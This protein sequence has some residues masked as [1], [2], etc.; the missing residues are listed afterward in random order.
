MKVS[1]NRLVLLAVLVTVALLSAA[2]A[3][4]TPSDFLEPRQADI[5][6][7]GQV[8]VAE[9]KT[10]EQLMELLEPGNQVLSEIVLAYGQSFS[11]GDTGLVDLSGVF[12]PYS[13][14]NASTGGGR[15]GGGCTVFIRGDANG[16]QDVNIADPNYISAY[17]FASGPPPPRM[18]AADSDDNGSITI[19]DSIYILQWLYQQG[20]KPP[21]PFGRSNG[22]QYFAGLDPTPDSLDAE[23]DL[24]PENF[25]E[26]HPSSGEGDH[27]GDSD[28]DSMWLVPEYGIIKV[29]EIG[30]Y[31]STVF[32]SGLLEDGYV[33]FSLAVSKS[34]PICVLATREGDG[35][36]RVIVLLDLDGDGDAQDSGERRYFTVPDNLL[37]GV[38][39]DASDSG[40]LSRQ[41]LVTLHETAAGE[42]L[43]VISTDSDSDGWL[44]GGAQVAVTDSILEEPKGLSTDGLTG[45][46]LVSGKREINSVLTPAVVF[47]HDTTG[48]K[49]I[50]AGSG[51]PYYDGTSL[52]GDDR[53]PGLHFLEEERTLVVLTI[54]QTEDEGSV[55][56]VKDKEDEIYV[57]QES[58]RSSSL[59]V[60]GEGLV[61]GESV[62]FPRW[63][64]GTC[65]SYGGTDYRSIFVLYGDGWSV[66]VFDV[67]GGIGP[68]S[69]F[70]P[71]PSPVPWVSLPDAGTL[72]SDKSNSHWCYVTTTDASEWGICE[73]P[74]ECNFH[75]AWLVAR[76]SQDF[77]LRAL[78]AYY[79]G[80]ASGKDAASKGRADEYA[81]PPGLTLGGDAQYVWHDGD[82]STHAYIWAESTVTWDIDIVAS[83]W[84]G[85]ILST[86]Y[87]LAGKIDI[88]VTG[89]S[90]GDFASEFF[91]TNEAD[92]N[93][94]EPFD[95]FEWYEV[96][97]REWVDYV[98]Q[99]QC[100]WEPDY[101]N[102]GRWDGGDGWANREDAQQ[103]T[104]GP[105]D[106]FH[107]GVVMIMNV[108]RGGATGIGA[109]ND[110]KAYYKVFLRFRCSE[111]EPL[112]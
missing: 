75:W 111:N 72:E 84:T 26:F 6:G 21:V 104:V 16:D 99:P 15:D 66:I 56:C 18:D 19:G 31:Q 28:L 110:E 32:A 78:E 91:D 42:E 23:C 71:L 79:Q 69:C 59:P 14:S 64:K 33:P 92:P 29:E 73:E 82:T 80:Q 4:E 20:P 65:Y 86:K 74:N 55:V 100:D 54:A 3:S 35:A 45:R 88:D 47:Y 37:D 38:L 58:C 63:I 107:V 36:A 94:G 22:N 70:D 85:P 83:G 68:G 27:L 7:D 17:L 49:K 5:D 2:A 89:D 61:G 101:G 52:P 60:G 9:V 95:P 76:Y 98:G 1:A 44:D 105:G 34:G 46:I 25:G 57:W 13:V 103:A 30:S 40:H 102:F 12:A 90:I 11:A 112:Q 24:R 41:E 48:D 67:A 77:A 62:G 39:T 43:L 81:P 87:R 96:T 53:Y 93:P 10:F 97:Y 50:D 8:S 109:G 108:E 106:D 51:T